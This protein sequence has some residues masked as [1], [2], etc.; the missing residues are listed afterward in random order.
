MMVHTTVSSIYFDANSSILELTFDIKITKVYFIFLL[1]SLEKRILSYGVELQYF[2][3][4]TVKLVRLAL[5]Q[6]YH[7]KLALL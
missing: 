7:N 2:K 5:A 4:F 1:N 3:A 6:Y